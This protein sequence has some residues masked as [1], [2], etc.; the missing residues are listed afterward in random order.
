MIVAILHIARDKIKNR[1]KAKKVRGDAPTEGSLLQ[2]LAA[3]QA[4][5]ELEQANIILPNM[6]DQMAGCPQLAEGE[7]VMVFVVKN[8][9]QRG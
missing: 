8:V 5:T 1:S 4:V 6:V 7:L 9:H 2:L 3:V